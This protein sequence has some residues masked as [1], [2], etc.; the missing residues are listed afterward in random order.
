MKAVVCPRYGPPEVLRVQ[1]VNRPVPGRGEV[2]VR[3]HAAAVTVSDCYIRGFSVPAKFWI[4]MALAVGF[5]R[6]RNPVLGMALAGEI[7]A[8]GPEVTRFRKGD[9]VFAHTMLRRGAHAEYT[10]VPE[11]GAIARMPSNVTYEQAAAIPYGGLLALHFLKGKIGRGQKVLVHG[12]SGAVGTAAIQ[13]ARSFGAEVT[14][15][16][17]AANHELVRSLGAGVVIDYTREDFTER[18]ERYDVIF[19]AAGK[20]TRSRCRKALE[21]G[22]EFV[23]VNGKGN[24]HPPMEDLVLLGEL[25]ESGRM[26]AVIDSCYPMEK[27]VEAHTHVETRHKKGNVIVTV[28]T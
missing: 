8:A 9:R 22:G 4:P 14:G 18:R 6:P 28:V 17:S 24:L 27:I 13:L 7:E 1:E 23:S 19:D 2:L 10:C 25:V 11:A 20:T 15:V 5:P 16:C 21:P 26:R 12:A 3:T